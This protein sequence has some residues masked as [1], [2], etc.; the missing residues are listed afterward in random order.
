M[1]AC[2]SPSP[3]QSARSMA[4]SVEPGD[5]TLHRIPYRASSSPSVLVYDAAA[6]FDAPY[7]AIRTRGTRPA[8][9]ATV[10]IAPDRRRFIPAATARE[11]WNTPSRLTAKAARQSTS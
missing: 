3:D 11:Q 10:T 9:D 6:A 8:L 5:T 4:V 7:A 2:R 1:V